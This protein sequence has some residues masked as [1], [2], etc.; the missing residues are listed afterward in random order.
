MV[1]GEQHSSRTHTRRDEGV[2]RSLT[3]KGKADQADAADDRGWLKANPWICFDRPWSAFPFLPCG[4]QRR[5]DAPTRG[6]F[7]RVTASIRPRTDTHE[8]LTAP[9]TQ[10][11][12][13][14]P[15]PFSAE[16]TDEANVCHL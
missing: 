7:R 15:A 10:T 14:A 6:S 1:D 2:G 11:Q 9:S 4:R 3:G 8:N 16:G 13:S 5:L 12:Q